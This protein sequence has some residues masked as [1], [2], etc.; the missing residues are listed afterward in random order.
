LLVTIGIIIS[1]VKEL[2][3]LS[4]F[5]HLIA[6]ALPLF[7]LLLQRIISDNERKE[8]TKKLNSAIEMKIKEKLRDGY[9][10]DTARQF[11]NEIFDIRRG[12]KLIPNYF[13]SLFK[14]ID[15][16]TINDARHI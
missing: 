15:N 14:K 10:K 7:V 1:F 13:Y 2:T 9:I 11:Q 8:K 16:K 12:S 4:M 6:P 3:V 5:L